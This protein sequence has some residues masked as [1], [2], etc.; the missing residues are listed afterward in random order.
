MAAFTNEEYADIVYM[1]GRADGNGLQARRLYQER[2]PGRRLPNVT[3]FYNTYR[4]L[5]ETGSVKRNEPGVNP[6]RHPPEV[7]DLILQAFAVDPTTSTRKIAADLGLSTWKVW[8]TMHR[9]GKYPFHGIGVQGLEDGD[10]IRRSQ[11][12][13]FL[14][15]SDI[16]NERFLESILWTDESNFS[17]EGICNFHNLHEW[18]DKHENP[19]WKKQ[20]SFQHKFSVNVWAG[21]IGHRLIGPYFLPERLNGDSYLEFLQNALPELLEGVQFPDDMQIVFQ[22]DGCPAH[23][24][25]D[26]RQYLNDTFPNSWIGR[27]GPIPWPARSPDLTPLDFYV[28]GRAKELVYTEEIVSR[29]HLIRKIREAFQL[30]QQDRLLHTTTTEVRRRA[31]A[32]IRNN[33]SHFEHQ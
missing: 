29:D 9:E 6:G 24:R 2:F 12:C 19:H 8:S 31:R 10:P 25:L 32:C 20:V 28:W 11:F 27:G 4:R 33:G 13:R 18:A 30:M 14:L 16:E 21:V 3:V 15:N 7:E 22:N 17:K 26:V 23:F 1:Y 5:Y